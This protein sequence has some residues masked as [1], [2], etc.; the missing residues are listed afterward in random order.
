M[1][2]IGFRPF[3]PRW[4]RWFRATYWS[5]PARAMKVARLLGDKSCRSTTVTSPGPQFPGWAEAPRE[6]CCH[7]RQ[8]Q[9]GAMER[10]G[11]A[12]GDRRAQHPRRAEERRV[13]NECVSTC[14]SRGSRYHTKKNKTKKSK[15]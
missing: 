9:G 6:R 8:R 12:P 3:P 14:R 7:G 2:A 11:G 15:N 4:R 13:G 10:R 1:S 5:L